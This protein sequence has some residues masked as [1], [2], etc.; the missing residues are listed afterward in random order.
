MPVFNN[1]YYPTISTSGAVVPLLHPSIPS[2]WHP[3]ASHSISTRNDNSNIDANFFLMHLLAYFFGTRLQVSE[4]W[5]D[6]R[7]PKTGQTH[8]IRF[9]H[10]TLEDFVSHS[11][12]SWRNWDDKKRKYITNLLYMHSR[13]PCYE[14]DWES[15]TIEYMVI[16]GLFAFT[17]N[18]KKTNI[19]HGKRMTDMAG[20][21]G[22]PLGLTDKAK[23]HMDQII[24]LRNDLLHEALWDKGSPC[25]PA[26]DSA[27]YKRIFL[28]NFVH[29]VIPAIFA[30]KTSY[31]ETEWW[32]IFAHK[33]EKAQ[34]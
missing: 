9:N 10:A 22:I 16:D 15:F 11:F 20:E 6:T 33:F 21:F 14:Y 29:R 30:Y 12:N 4:W 17:K 26:S 13:A 27:F 23:I 31:I 2:F 3:P 18:F 24:N 8:H 1:Y 34:K 25:N 32:N 5:F 19:K 7:V 28:R